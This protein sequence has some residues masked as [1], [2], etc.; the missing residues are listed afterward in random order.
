MD[1]DGVSPAIP[2]S[3]TSIASTPPPID[4]LLFPLPVCAVRGD[5]ARSMPANVYYTVPKRQLIVLMLTLP[6]LGLSF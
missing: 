2:P 5:E 4:T 3:A 1:M 6:L